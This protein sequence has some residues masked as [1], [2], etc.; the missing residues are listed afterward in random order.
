MSKWPV[1]IILVLVSVFFYPVFTK[2]F[3]PIPADHVVGIYYPWLDYK[4]AGYLAGVPVKNPIAADVISFM[5]PMQ[6]F[7]VELMKKGQWPLWNPLILAGTPLLAN[8]QSAPLSIVNIFYWIFDIPMAWTMQII[9]QQ[10]LGMVF[11]FLLL[12]YF[13]LSK[14]SSLLGGLIYAFS[15]F[16]MIWLEWNGHGLV[17]ALF[18]LVILLTYKFLDEPRIR[19]GAALAA[20]VAVQIFAGYPQVIIYEFLALGLG[21]VLFENIFKLYRRILFMGIFVLLGIGMGMV[22]ILPGYELIKLSQRGVEVVYPEWALLSPISIIRFIAPDYFGNH[23]T[24]NYWGPAD[25]TQSVGYSG[26]V[27]ITLA[28]LG[29][30]SSYKKKAV[31]IGATWIVVS[32]IV[33]F[34]TPLSRFAYQNGFLASQASSSH[35]I[36]VLSNLGVAILAGFGLEYLILNKPSFRQIIRSTYFSG[37]I[38][39]AFTVAT[40]GILLYID[41]EK[42]HNNLIIG[43]RNMVLPAAFLFIA[44]LIMISKRY[45]LSAKLVATLF[46]LLTAVELFRFGWKFTPFTDKQL[47]FPTTPVIEYLQKQEKPFRVNAN[48][49][50]PINLIM[51][52]RIETIEGYDA[53]YPMRFAKFISALNSGRVDSETMGRYGL[54]FNP[55]S[56]LLDLANVKYLLTYKKLESGKIDPKGEVGAEYNSGRY[57]K[58][59]EDGSVAVIENK[60]TLPRAKM[61][62]DWEIEVNDNKTLAKLLNAYPIPSKVILAQDPRISPQK[63]VVNTVSLES[64]TQKNEIIVNTSAPGVLLVTNSMYPG[65]KALV[66]GL[67][68]D[69]ILADYNFMGIVIRHPGE[70]RIKLIFEPD[71]FKYGKALSFISAMIV[72]SICLGSYIIIW[73]TNTTKRY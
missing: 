45:F 33:A 67:Q 71:S 64:F 61:F 68:E 30:M 62:Y 4:W 32:L 18:P 73:C 50:V 34:D 13:N 20:V 6:T 23:A 15:G 55:K 24:Y 56:Q 11:V 44:V 49:V 72:F 39:L 65:W 28:S 1:L 70:H 63:E 35:R 7:A 43:I 40:L 46:I 8:F 2:G 69:I 3:I 52:Y 5:Y 38:L 58:V 41:L 37:I 47:I 59:F 48:E 42:I 9:L 22:Q 10:I 27:A 16:M 14:Q 54:I 57:R 19:I 31:R 51:P 66:D 36:F 25:Y 21:I 60:N 26:V 17:A 53:V 12:R 29:I